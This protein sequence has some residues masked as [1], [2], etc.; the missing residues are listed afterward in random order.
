MY[1][2]RKTI[3][4]SKEKSS[5]LAL[6]SWGKDKA[7]GQAHLCKTILDT[8]TLL[9]LPAICLIAFNCCLPNSD[10]SPRSCLLVGNQYTVPCHLSKEYFITSRDTSEVGNPQAKRIIRI[11]FSP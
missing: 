6:V 10:P 11:Y 5:S 8:M 4:P 2:V 3:V 7:L 9:A 1:N